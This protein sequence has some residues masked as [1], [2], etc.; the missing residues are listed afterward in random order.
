MAMSLAD[1]AEPVDAGDLKSSAPN[2]RAGSSPAVRTI[3][4]RSLS[5]GQA[6]IAIQ[7]EA[8]REAQPVRGTDEHRDP[9]RGEFEP[10]LK[11]SGFE[12]I[13]RIWKNPVIPS[14]SVG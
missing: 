14:I 1:V 3:A 13:Y 5:G 4:K 11:A 2:G 10:L 6:S 9:K 8:R 7:S 12:R